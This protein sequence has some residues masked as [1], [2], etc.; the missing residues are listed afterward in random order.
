MVPCA[1]VE[2]AGT[3][4]KS[5]LCTADVSWSEKMMVVPAE[6]VRFAGE[7]L[8]DMLLPMPAGRMIVLVRL[9]EDEVVVEPVVLLLVELVVVVLV[10]V[11]L[12]VGMVEVVVLVV[13]VRLV[14]VVVLEPGAKIK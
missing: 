2:P 4:W 14:D 7:K 10:V 3:L 1:T 6:T 12:V 13:V 8:R 9:P 5:M 11:V